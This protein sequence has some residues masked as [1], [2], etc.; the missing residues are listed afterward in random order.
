M[1][2]ES[3]PFYNFITTAFFLLSL[4]PTSPSNVPPPPSLTPGPEDIYGGNLKLILGLIWTLIGKY[5]IKSSGKGMS[6]KKAMLGWITTV[7]PEYLIA[8]FSTGWNDGRAVCGMVDRIR[9]GLCPNHFALDKNHGLENCKLGM[10]LADQHL[11]IPKVLTPEDLNNP[12]VDDLSVMTYLSYFCSPYNTLLMQWIRQKIPRRN[13]KN[14]STDWNNGLNLGALTEACFPG[15]CPD[16]ET[17][18]PSNAIQNNER[19][20]ALINE[21]LGINCP[22]S[23]TELAD[24]KMDEIVV[25]TYLHHFRNA[26]LRTSPEEFS[27]LIPPLAGGCAIVQEPFTFEVLV[28]D[29]AIGLTADIAIQAHGP[30][31]DAAVSIKPQPDSSNLMASF[32]PMEAG[33]Y[34]IIA[35][36]SGQ[37]IQG[38]P[39]QLH[40]ADSTKC[41]F[42]GNLPGTLHV[43]VAEEVVVKTIGAG[44][45]KL[46]CSIAR[47]DESSSDVVSV[48]L[49]DKGG[50]TYGIKLEPQSLGTATV[51]VTWA[52]HDIPSSPFTVKVCDASQCSFTGLTGEEGEEHVVGNPVTFTVSTEEAGEGELEVKPHGTSAQYSPTITSTGTQHEV[53]FTPWEVGAHQIEIFWEGSHIPGSPAPLEIRAA[54]DI[55]ACSATGAGLKRGIAEKPNTFKILSPEKGLLERKN[56]LNVTVSS[57]DG[58][59]PMEITDNDDSTYTVTYM[60]P[61]KGAHVASIKFYEKPIAGSP[62]KI[63]VVPAADASKCRAYGPA[64]HP[65]SLHITGTPLDLFVDTENAGTGELQVVIKGPNDTRP[66]VY[67]ANEDGVH[68]LK[69][70][71]LDAGKYY[72]HIWWSQTPIPG[73]PFKVKVYPGPTAANVVTHGPG[74][75]PTVKVGDK[76]EFTVDTK[77]AGIG[78]LT[79]R[80]HGVVGK[81]KIEANPKDES[82][83]RTLIAHYDPQEA[84]DYII[85]IRWSGVHIPNSPFHVHILDEEEEQ[86]QKKQSQKKE[87]ESTEEK[88]AESAPK[89]KGQKKVEETDGGARVGGASGRPRLMSKEE[90]QAYQ[91]Q[92][93]MMM[94][95]GQPLNPAFLAAGGAVAMEKKYRLNPSM[96][97]ATF[98]PGGQVVEVTKTTVSKKVE[99]KKKGKK[100]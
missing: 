47:S 72:V 55:N 74:L 99:K 75:E 84:G 66:K 44:D 80:V 26:K 16:W 79:V 51:Q 90:I 61:T 62:F 1:Q 15:V 2:L 54:P 38:S 32:V 81:F 45:G 49:E 92:Q 78:T 10:D 18:D 100:F 39:F 4:S 83:P 82:T 76:G 85:A 91:Q 88:G 35:S 71:V 57:A 89:T 31:S 65:N 30:K 37:N 29:P 60:P 11:D 41:Q 13:I 50:D 25:A 36:Y 59:V 94:A 68:S 33:S 77:N 28:S 9:P 17:M 40:V 21:R 70:D 93:Q 42:L 23:A 43:G 22:V 63:N 5:Q 52:E 97:P 86:R 73:S 64:L 58:E 34:D 96:M 98:V 14:L 48:T 8:N 7:I 3:H 27:L 6:T 87:A 19:M 20:I 24:P 46:G 67:Q 69:F 95:A 53:S 12:E 56:G